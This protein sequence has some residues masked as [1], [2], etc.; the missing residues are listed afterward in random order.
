MAPENTEP[1]EGVDFEPHPELLMA[2]RRGD[3][4]QLE[5]LLSQKHDAAAPPQPAPPP[6]ARRHVIVRIDRVVDVESASTVTSVD[7]VTVARDSVLHVVAS[8]G[9]ADRFLKSATVIYDR[10]RHLL[11]ARNGA[12][13]TPLHCAVR[14]GW[15]GMVA[16]LVALARRS[17]NGGGG[18]GGDDE[19]VKAMLRMQNEQGETVLHEAV[20]LGSRD[21]VAQLMSEDPQLA[22]VPPAD[23]ASP[24]YVAV[25]LDHDDIARQLY[26]KDTGL[27]YSG[28]D[29]R[30]ALHEAALKGKGETFLP[31]LL[32]HSFSF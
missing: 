28:P 19:R 32:S 11:D 10:A 12:G 24:L 31:I 4:E 22:R 30:N 18:G 27:S 26:Q 16:H 1:N 14:A 20:R 8:R 6:P 21:M 5:R 3:W 29:G 25:S 7:A 13:D 2:A 17:D 15:G 23:G 9:E